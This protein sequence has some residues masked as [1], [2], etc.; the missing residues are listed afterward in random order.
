MFTIGRWD[1]YEHLEECL[2][3]DELIESYIGLQKG[4]DR[5][6]ENMA[7]MWGATPKEDD[8]LELGKSEPKDI[9]EAPV[10]APGGEKFGVGFG[11]GHTEI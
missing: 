4:N 1:N 8:R 10:S 7:R 6:I 9:V 11:L 2:T 5:L 3:I